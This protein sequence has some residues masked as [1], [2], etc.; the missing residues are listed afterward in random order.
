[1]KENVEDHDELY[2]CTI[3]EGEKD[4]EAARK[5]R[6]VDR[7]QARSMSEQNPSRNYKVEAAFILQR[8]AE[9]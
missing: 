2:I 8:R 3:Q 1:M 5:K 9:R 4:C 6:A 7:A